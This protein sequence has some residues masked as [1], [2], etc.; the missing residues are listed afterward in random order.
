MAMTKRAKSAITKQSDANGAKPKRTRRKQGA[1]RVRSELATQQQE[2]TRG[3]E[4]GCVGDSGIQVQQE[5]AKLKDTLPAV[6]LHMMTGFKG[7]EMFVG[8]AGL[9]AEIVD[10]V[11]P[12]DPLERMLVQ[13]LV[14][15]QQRIAHLSMKACSQSNP[16][17]LRIVNE[18]VDRAMNSYRRGMLALREYRAPYRPVNINAVSQLNQAEQQNILLAEKP[19]STAENA[20]NEQ[21]T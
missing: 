10:G 16:D 6:V 18:L 7:S 1:Q 5:V 21:G 20:T 12:R 2:A 13:Q 14:W 3:D 9:M 19:N 4:L 17:R 15:C 11:S 8:A